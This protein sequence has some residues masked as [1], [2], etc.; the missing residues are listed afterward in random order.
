MSLGLQGVG[1]GSGGDRLRGQPREP[2]CTSVWVL[3]AVAAA[4]T[5]LWVPPWTRELGPAVQT[6]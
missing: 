1:T 6:C 3:G 4:C 5:E 2:V